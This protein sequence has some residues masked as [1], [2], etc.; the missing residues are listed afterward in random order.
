MSWQ[1]TAKEMA[2]GKWIKF[3]AESPNHTI[4]FL[5]EP[6]V[7]TKESKIQGKEGETYE[8]MSFPVEEEGKDRILEPNK[9]LL[10]LIVEEDSEESIMGRTFLVKCLDV[11]R[12]QQW[13]IREVASEGKRV[14][15]FTARPTLPPAQA[16]P[17]AITEAPAQDEKAKEKFMQEVKK[18][19]KTTKARKPTKEEMQDIADAHREPEEEGLNEES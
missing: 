14:Q 2:K 4:T 6:T 7:V 12:K 8:V 17:E 16:E 3:D 13:K 15:D 10:R 18:R 5:S 11:V 1:K 19:T 9:S